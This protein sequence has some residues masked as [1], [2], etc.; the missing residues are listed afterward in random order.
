MGQIKFTYSKFYRI[1]GESTQ[2]RGVLPDIS[3]P[4]AFN[5]DEFGE[6][7]LPNAL[8]W[9]VISSV[10]YVPVG[11]VQSLIPQ[12]QKVHQKRIANDKDFDEM[13]E[14]INEYHTNSE[15]TTVSL[16]LEKRDK[17][18]K[19]REQKILDRE[20][21]RLESLGL[22]KISSIDDIDNEAERPDPLMNETAQIL[23]D[24]IDL[25]D[26]QKLAYVKEPQQIK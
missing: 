19:K 5:S 17:L 23:K 25:I 6:S 9:D 22:E 10:D 18:R 15:K 21:A 1:N 2:N 4:T 20:N 14:D 3:F 7:A 11:D 12:L 24:Y 8:P 13:V 26:G 16:N